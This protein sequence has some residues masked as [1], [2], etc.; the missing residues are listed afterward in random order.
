MGQRGP[1]PT[2]VGLQLLRGN[3]GKRRLNL[4][5]PKPKSRPT[6]PVGMSD[7][8]RA[9]WARII[10]SYGRT[11]ILTAVDADA[12]RIYCEAVVR[13]TQAAELLEEDG[14]LVPGS[15]RG[16]LVKN[17][18][19]QVMRDNADLVRVL[20]REFGFTPSARNGLTN[21][22]AEPDADPI[23]TWMAR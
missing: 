6:P 12:L 17:P 21:A 18:L 14:P 23:E 15:H 20:A 11:G 13:Y 10:R 7:A 16:Q 8:S 2:P 9:I 4:D 1:A 22:E 3:P 19:H 5:T